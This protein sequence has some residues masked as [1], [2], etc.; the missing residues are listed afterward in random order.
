MDVVLLGMSRLIGLPAEYMP[1]GMR[2]ADQECEKRNNDEP[3]HHQPDAA[4][5]GQSRDTALI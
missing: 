3:N 2:Q 1:Y 5:T 4:N